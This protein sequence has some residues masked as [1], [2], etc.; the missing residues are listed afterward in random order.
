MSATAPL[1]GSGRFA[2]AG[3]PG[4]ASR[5]A[6]AW[7][8]LASTLWGWLRRRVGDDATADDLLQTVFL[9]VHERG[10][11]LRDP[12]RI[13]A[14]VWQ[15]ARHA[16]L[17]HLRARRPSVDLDDVGDDPAMVVAA[18][19]PDELAGLATWLATQI[20]ALP[21]EQA[22]ALRLTEF[23]GLTM[24]QAAGRLGLSVS[25]TKSRVQRG[26]AELRRVLLRCCEVELDRHGAPTDFRRKRLGS[27]CND[28]CAAP[29]TA[30]AACAGPHQP[31]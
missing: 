16:L 17:D 2:I 9:R 1:Q 7:Q 15:V 10:G 13:D 6:S 25:G 8:S 4:P 27:D 30:V 24:Q 31:S 19:S 11:Q 22:A 26:R 28:S 23:E 5:T 29:E 20:A 21:P 18:E 3:A 12:E 14:W